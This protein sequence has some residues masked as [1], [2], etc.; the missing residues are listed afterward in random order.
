MEA[1]HDPH[2][3]LRRRGRQPRARE[4]PEEGR[5]E[6]AQ[7]DHHQVDGDAGPRARRERLELVL[8]QGLALRGGKPASVFKA[9]LAHYLSAWVGGVGEAG[10]RNSRLG[11]VPCGRVAVQGAGVRRHR[12]AGWDDVAA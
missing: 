2:A 1:I 12:R 5:H 3:P 8:Y 11:L 6:E 4:L 9:V 7:F 10:C